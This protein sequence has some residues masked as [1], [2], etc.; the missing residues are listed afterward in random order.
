M[1]NT[2]NEEIIERLDIIIKL[3]SAISVKD[4]NLK[5]Q[6]KVLSGLDLTPKQISRALRKNMN[7]IRVMKHSIKKE[8]EEKYGKNRKEI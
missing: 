3:L 2:M 1:K 7:L 8:E 5:D 6:I 4:M